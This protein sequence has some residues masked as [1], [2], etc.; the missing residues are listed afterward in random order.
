MT[1]SRR[2]IIGYLII[3]IS[4]VLFGAFVQYAFFE[5]SA[6]SV[7]RQKLNDIQALVVKI[8]SDT[9]NYQTTNER[10]YIYTV[11]DGIKSFNTL[12]KGS[13]FNRLS[14]DLDQ[15]VI[16]IMTELNGFIE[17]LNNYMVLNDQLFA[18]NTQMTQTTNEMIELI[19]AYK[20]DLNGH[21]FVFYVDLMDILMKI[22]NTHDQKNGRSERLDKNHLEEVARLNQI[23]DA[24]ISSKGDL[25]MKLL[26]ARIKSLG[27]KHSEFY[28][29][30]VLYN[31]EEAHFEHLLTQ[32]T[33]NIDEIVSQVMVLE[34][35]VFKEKNQ[36]IIYFSV[37]ILVFAVVVATYTSLTITFRMK[38]NFNHLIEVTQLIS[39]GGYTK[40]VGFSDDRD[41]ELLGSSINEMAL[42][43][44]ESRHKLEEYNNRLIIM[45]E[46]KTKELN[47]ANVELEAIND[48][49]MVEKERLSIA[50]MTDYLTQLKNR[51]YLVDFLRQRIEEFKRYDKPFSILLL[52]VDRFKDVNDTYGHQVGDTVLK[53]IS[54]VI[55]SEIRHSDVAGRYGGE[56]FLVILTDTPL[57]EAI[58]VAERIRASIQ[59]YP[60]EEKNLKVTISGGL[61]TYRS[62]TEDEVLQKVD[63]LLYEAKAQG[64][65]K[66][67][68]DDYV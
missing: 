49:L 15:K 52:D 13:H 41:V 32:L 4:L 23:A 68:A 59:D 51:G 11:N 21:T 67:V 56:E 35:G 61:L 65:N 57:M 9:L 20:K 25:S 58:F 34:K 63:A 37:F 8:K 7:E 1:M 31:S 26:G 46:D 64:R 43:L 10:Q 16:L 36:S 18:L 47:D 62:E 27:E 17:V 3:I 29:K 5:I 39:S 28:D 48:S 53:S 66:I 42:K 55:L 2:V 22:N 38:N 6:F 60:H 54:S 50:A 19:S 30:L 12:Y 24:L 40:R 44:D 45:V 14:H 33:T